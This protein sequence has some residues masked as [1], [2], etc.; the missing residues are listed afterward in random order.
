MLSSTRHPN[1]TLDWRWAFSKWSWLEFGQ[2]PETFVQ[3]QKGG[4]GGL[5][6]GIGFTSLLPPALARD[7]LLIV[8]RSREV[9]GLAP[10]SLAGSLLA[11]EPLNCLSIWNLPHSGLHALCQMLSCEVPKPGQGL[12]LLG[13]TLPYCLR[14]L[15]EELA[16]PVPL[17]PSLWPGFI[18]III[19]LLTLR[20]SRS[21]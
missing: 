15:G 13:K 10:S 7:T 3:G 11:S 16:S 17:R 5:G 21:R 8:T 19:Y 14:A 4:P 20:P 2:N 12:Q 6:A 18:V 1:G 9:P